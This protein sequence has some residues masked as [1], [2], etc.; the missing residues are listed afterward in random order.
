MGTFLVQEEAKSG[1][2]EPDQGM[3][4]ATSSHRSRKNGSVQVVE[5]VIGDERFAIDLF[6][7][8]EVITIPEVTPIPNAHPCITGMIDLRGVITTIIDLRVMMN[9]TR[10]STGML[11]SG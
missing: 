7:T 5:F 4:K 9:I 1:Y 11:S 3:R 8:R 6:D 10:E 2:Q